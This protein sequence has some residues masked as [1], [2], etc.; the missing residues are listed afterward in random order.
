MYKWLK[1]YNEQFN[2]DFPFSEVADLSEYEIVRI[3][4][5]CCETG[6]EY[7]VPTPPPAPTA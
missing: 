5:E 1:Q 4:Q 7:T 2:K 6:K 3:L